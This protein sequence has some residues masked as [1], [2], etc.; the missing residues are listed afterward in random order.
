MEMLKG[1]ARVWSLWCQIEIRLF[2]KILDRFFLYAD[3]QLLHNFVLIIVIVLLY[4]SLV[5]RNQQTLTFV[6]LDNSIY[7]LI[8]QI[9]ENKM[10]ETGCHRKFEHDQVFSCFE[11]VA[12]IPQKG[13]KKA[14]SHS[15]SKA[16]RFPPV[17][18]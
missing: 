17:H 15:Y 3:L 7:D 1:L 10:F 16:R 14:L 11:Y 5:I 13:T 18:L 4:S 6:S 12:K 2:P 9:Q 8:S